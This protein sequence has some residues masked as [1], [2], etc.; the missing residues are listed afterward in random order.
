QDMRLH[1][2]STIKACT[3]LGRTLN[4][5]EDDTSM[6]RGN[7]GGC[8]SLGLS[9]NPNNTTKPPCAFLVDVNGDKKPTPANINCKTYDCQA[10]NKYFQLDPKSK[11]VKDIFTILITEDRAIPYGVVAQKAMYSAQK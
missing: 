7:C 2:S 6:G 1:E 8:G 10:Q 11:I 3:R 9:F 5:F 4:G